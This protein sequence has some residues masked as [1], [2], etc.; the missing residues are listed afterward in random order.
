MTDSGDQ[1]LVARFLSYLPPFA[2]QLVKYILGFGV[3]FALGLAR[4]LGAFGIPGFVPL[5][6][7]FPIESRV[8]LIPVSA[9]LMG[10]VAVGVQFYS[11]DAIDRR[12]LRKPFVVVSGV[13]VAG[14]VALLLLYNFVVPIGTSK[15]RVIVGW[16]RL[17]SPG[18]ECKTSDSDSKCV[19]GLA[20]ELGTCWTES[21]IRWVRNG[22]YLTYLLVTGGFVALV[23]L[24]ALQ[25][26]AKREERAV[27]RRAQRS[28]TRRATP[29]ADTASEP[30]AHPP[31]DEE[32]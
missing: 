31:A 4:F 11:D 6:A 13:L 25:Q 1:G 21:S 15:E 8:P 27:E 2:R 3:G 26:K 24:L 18:C 10:L 9:F 22:Y 32:Q 7:L 29:D 30:A 23:G 5:L 20:Q 28:K 12:S 16:S 17:P 19:A 14:L